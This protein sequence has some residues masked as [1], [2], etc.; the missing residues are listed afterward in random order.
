MRGFLLLALL[1]MGCGGPSPEFR[2]VHVTRVMMGISMFDV[3][4][5]GLH[6]EAVRVNTQYAPRLGQLGLKAVLAIEQVSGCRV[7]RLSGDA[8]M[9]EATLDCGEGAPDARVP[10]PYLECDAF[11]LE[12]DMG[13]MICYPF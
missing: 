12:T 13:E 11:D 5:T 1:L 7:D 4:V 9:V 6:A 2:K 10:V 8:A 3:L